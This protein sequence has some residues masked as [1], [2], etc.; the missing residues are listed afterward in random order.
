MSHREQTLMNFLMAL[1]LVSWTVAL[2]V[3]VGALVKGN[4][5][6]ALAAG[7]ALVGLTAGV[8]AAVREG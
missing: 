4:G 2:C 7:A 6:L 5:T 8:I 1:V 3:T